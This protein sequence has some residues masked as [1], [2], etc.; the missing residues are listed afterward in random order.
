MYNQYSEMEL[1]IKND[2][3]SLSGFA[4]TGGKSGDVVKIRISGV[5]LQSEHANDPEMFS[6][7]NNIEHTISTLIF[8]LLLK[9]FSNKLPEKFLLQSIRVEMFGEP[10][11]NCVYFNKDAKIL[12]EFK[13]VGSKKLKEGDPV[14]NSDV[15]KILKLTCNELNPNA[16]YMLFV[17]FQGE[18]YGVIDFTYN[19]ENASAKYK[20]AQKHLQSALDNFEKTNLQP[21]YDSL[22]AG[23]ELLGES[24]LLLHNQIKLKD[25]HKKIS[26][27][28][29]GFCKIHNMTFDK[30]FQIIQKIRD[31]VRYG[32]PHTIDVDIKENASIYLSN[33]MNFSKFVEKFLRERLVDINNSNSIHSFPIT[34]PKKE[35]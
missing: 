10:S 33:S 17:L 3:P 6:I 20:L 15:E 7:K 8:P 22:W 29:A 16:A 34:M 1:I 11:Q 14:L 28:L 30:D 27:T 18:W 21:F 26:K 13:F 32:P 19:R 25:S 4:M 31:V 9:H 24:V 5:F 23:C 35:S 12:G 2:F